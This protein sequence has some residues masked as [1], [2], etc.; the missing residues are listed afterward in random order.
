MIK[1]FLN[2]FFWKVLNIGSSVLTGILLARLLSIEGRGEYAIFISIVSLYTVILN[3]GIPES[4]VYLLQKEKESTSNLVKYGLLV[5]TVILVTLILLHGVLLLFNINILYLEINYII[6]PVFVCLIFGSYNVLLRHL[7]LKDNKIPIYNLLSSIETISNL[8]IFFILYL[9]NQFTLLN[10]IF[11]FTGT[12]LLSFIIHVGYLKGTLIN[13]YLNKSSFDYKIFKKLLKFALPLF[14]VGLSGI[15]STRL[16]LFILDYFHSSIN[17]GYFAI[18]IIFPNL[19][20]ILPNQIAAL[21]YPVASG[22][23]KNSELINYGNNI[24]KHIIF[25]TLLL[26]IIGSIVSPFLI[27][28][29]YGVRYVV[30]IPAVYIILIGVFFGGINSVLLNLLVSHGKSKILFYNAL[31]IIFG[32]ILFSFLVY[33]YSYKGTAIT[34]TIISMICFSISFSKY[35]KI[36]NLQ[37]SSLIIRRQDIKCL[38]TKLYNLLRK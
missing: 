8:V 3:F 37:L 35:K 12:I 31:I 20:L 9:V 26:V 36:T 27:P 7:V 11:V 34:F 32:V 2:S 10:I 30:V 14:F 15:F 19:L 33:L 25:F 29:L 13:F 6:V 21:L 16:N 4:L 24:L 38:R 17:V 28:L 1:F 22:I 5:P 18:A 23:E